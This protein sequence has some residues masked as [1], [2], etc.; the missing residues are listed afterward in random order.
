MV[1]DCFMNKEELSLYSW[2]AD[3]L[4]AGVTAWPTVVG[5]IVNGMRRRT[6]TP[7]ATAVHLITG[8]RAVYSTYAGD[9][10]VQTGDMLC[11][12][13]QISEDFYELPGEEVSLYWTRMDGAGAEQVARQWGVTPDHPVR[14][15]AITGTAETAFRSLFDYWSRSSRN[16]YEGL[17]LFYHLIAVSGPQEETTTP[18]SPAAVV[19]ES[20]II[21]ESLLETGINVNE[22]AEML[23][24]SRITLWRA[25]R[26]VTGKTAH[27]WIVNARIERACEFLRQTNLTL[28]EIAHACGFKQSKY[29]MR[30]FKNAMGSTPGEWRKKQ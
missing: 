30:C 15:A 10:T 7:K 17:S 18:S 11:M 28:G 14:H 9:H 22:L 16:V 19:N 21:I 1:Y 25:F 29:F 3:P 26:E 2:F 12:W 27:E 4:P 5:R 20:R 24:V 13:P 23:R 8:G 6:G